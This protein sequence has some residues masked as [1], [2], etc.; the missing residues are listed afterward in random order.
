MP[1]SSASSKA[2]IIHGGVGKISFDAKALEE[3]VRAFADAVV[4]ARPAGAKGIYVQKVAIPRRWGLAS[5]S[6]RPAFA[7]AEGLPGVTPPVIP[8]LSGPG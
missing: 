1:S 6:T 8:G 5:R 4:K 2:G 3:N 7:A